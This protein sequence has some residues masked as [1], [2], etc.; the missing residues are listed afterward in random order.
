MAQISHVLLLFTVAQVQ[1]SPFHLPRI[2]MMADLRILE[3]RIQKKE[4]IDPPCQ[5]SAILFDRM[6][7]GGRCGR[8]SCPS[9][10]ST[11]A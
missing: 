3:W 4:R 2:Q 9:F 10:P 1:P 7:G 8:R 11:I 5:V 6:A